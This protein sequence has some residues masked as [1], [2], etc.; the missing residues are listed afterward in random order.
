MLDTGM[1]VVIQKLVLAEK[2]GVLFTIDPVS[3][4]CGL[5]LLNANYGLGEV[6]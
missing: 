5:M 1:G 2:S 4:N 6:R 3:E